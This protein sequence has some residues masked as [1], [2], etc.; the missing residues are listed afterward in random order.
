MDRQFEAAGL[1]RRPEIET[2]PLRG[3]GTGRARTFWNV[4]VLEAEGATPAWPSR[5]SPERTLAELGL[6][7]PL[8]EVADR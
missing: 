3:H 7:H 4:Y 1:T 5:V 8:L 6:E 2:P